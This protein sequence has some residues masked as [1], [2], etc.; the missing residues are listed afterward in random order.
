[1]LVGFWLRIGN[2]TGKWHQK[3]LGVKWWAI[4][5][6]KFKKTEAG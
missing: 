3:D 1:M 4:I 6:F 2:G 5:H